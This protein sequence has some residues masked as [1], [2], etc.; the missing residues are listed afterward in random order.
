MINIQ[1]QR[2][3]INQGISNLINEIKDDNRSIL[4]IENNIE[5][6]VT[7]ELILL[8]NIKTLR[9]KEDSNITLDIKLKQM[10]QDLIYKEKKLI[11]NQGESHVEITNSSYKTIEILNN[12]DQILE[13]KA[14][15]LPIISLNKKNKFNIKIEITEKYNIYINDILTSE[16]YYLNENKLKIGNNEIIFDK[17]FKFVINYERIKSNNNV[18]MLNGISDI[19]LCNKEY[20]G[21]KLI[22]G[23][24]TSTSISLEK[25]NNINYIDIG[26][27][28]VEIKE[29][30]KELKC[31]NSLII[32]NNGKNN[33]IESINKIGSEQSI[34]LNE[35]V[36]L[37]SNIIEE[38]SKIII[39]PTN[40]KISNNN[41]LAKVINNKDI[42][43]TYNN[44][45]LL[46]QGVLNTNKIYTV[47]VK[48]YFINVNGVKM[49]DGDIVISESI[50]NDPIY[51][52]KFITNIKEEENIIFY[53][54][55]AKYYLQNCHMVNGLTVDL[56]IKNI[57][58]EYNND[59]YL[60]NG[61]KKMKILDGGIL[62][63]NFSS[64]TSDQTNNIINIDANAS[65]IMYQKKNSS[66]ILYT[67]L[68]NG[69][70]ELNNFYDIS[71]SAPLYLE[72]NSLI[73]GN[74][75]NTIGEDFSNSF[76]I[77]SG[78]KDIIA[79]LAKE[80]EQYP[81][82]TN[83]EKI[84]IT[85]RKNDDLL[86]NTGT[87]NIKLK[88]FYGKDLLYKGSI[89][90]NDNNI[91]IGD[92]IYTLN[93][94]C[95]Y[96]PTFIGEEEININ[97]NIKINTTNIKL[98]QKI[99][100]DL[101]LESINHKQFYMKNYYLKNYINFKLEYKD[102]YCNLFIKQIDESYIACA[103][104]CGIS[105]NNVYIDQGSLKGFSGNSS[106]YILY[107]IE[108]N[109]V[110]IRNENFKKGFSSKNENYLNIEKNKI[111]L[112]S[113]N[114]GIYEIIQDNT[115]FYLNNECPYFC[116]DICTL[117]TYENNN[118]NLYL[119]K[120]STT[121]NNI[122]FSSETFQLV[123][124]ANT[125]Y[126]NF[127]WENSLVNAEYGE[128]R[129]G[130]KQYP[131][132]YN[133]LLKSG[134]FIPPQTIY[135][136]L[137]LKIFSNNFVV[138]F[139]ENNTHEI[140]LLN[141]YNL[142]GYNSVFLN[143]NIYSYQDNKI[144]NLNINKE[145]DAS[146]LNINMNG[147][148]I[149]STNMFNDIYF[150]P[151]TINISKVTFN[152]DYPLF[153][154]L[155]KDK[156]NNL[157][158]SI[159]DMINHIY[160]NIF[161]PDVIRNIDFNLFRL[162]VDNK[163]IKKPSNSIINYCNSISSFSGSKNV[164]KKVLYNGSW[165]FYTLEPSTNNFYKMI[166]YDTNL[167]ILPVNFYI[168][169]YFN[170]TN[171]VIDNLEITQDVNKN[172][173]S[174]KI[175]NNVIATEIAG[176]QSN[177]N[178]FFIPKSNNEII[179]PTSINNNLM[180]CK[181]L[182]DTLMIYNN[183]DNKLYYTSSK[184]INNILYDFSSRLPSDFF[185]LYFG[186][187]GASIKINDSKT[188]SAPCNTLNLKSPDSLG[189]LGVNNVTI[190]VPSVFS[191]E[192]EIDAN[193]NLKLNITNSNVNITNGNISYTINDFL[194]NPNYDGLE[195]GDNIRLDKYLTKPLYA[196]DTGAPLSLNNAVINFSNNNILLPNGKYIVYNKPNLS[197][198]KLKNN[199]KDIEIYNDLFPNGF[200]IHNYNEVLGSTTLTIDGNG[201]SQNRGKTLSC[202][203]MNRG[204]Y[205]SNNKE[206]YDNAK[207]S[208]K[209]TTAN[210][211]GSFIARVGSETLYLPEQDIYLNSI[212]KKDCFYD[213]V[214]ASSNKLVALGKNNVLKISTGTT[215]YINPE[216]QD[217][218]APGIINLDNLLLA[219]TV[220][221]SQ[222]I[223]DNNGN[224]IDNLYDLKIFSD[225][226]FKPFIFYGAYNKSDYDNKLT[227]SLCNDKT[228]LVIKY[229]SSTKTK[230]ISNIYNQDNTLNIEESN[231]NI[232]SK[233][234]VPNSGN[235]LDSYVLNR[236]IN[237][238]FAWGGG[239][240][241]K[242]KLINNFQSYAP[243]ICSF[244][245]NYLYLYTI[246]T[247]G[248]CYKLPL[249]N[250]NSIFN[251]SNPVILKAV[252][253]GIE[254]NY[255]NQTL[256]LYSNLFA[257][258]LENNFY[259]PANMKYWTLP[260]EIHNF[261]NMKVFT[262]RSVVL[263]Y[264]KNSMEFSNKNA[265]MTDSPIIKFNLDTYNY[266]SP[267]YL[268]VNQEGIYGYELKNPIDTM[269][270]NKI[271]TGT[272]NKYNFV[273]F[274]NSIF[275]MPASTTTLNYLFGNSNI[276]I[277]NRYKTLEVRCV[278][279]NLILD[280]IDLNNNKF[281]YVLNKWLNNN[282]VYSGYTIYTDLNIILGNNSYNKNIIEFS[283]ITPI[284]TT[285]AM[286]LF[287]YNIKLN[288][289]CVYTIVENNKLN[290]SVRD[291][292][293]NEKYA[294]K[295]A[296]WLTDTT[297]KIGNT[298]YG[299][300]T[301][302]VSGLG[303]IAFNTANRSF[304]YNIDSGYNLNFF[305]RQNITINEK[306]N[307]KLIGDNLC[308]TNAN[309]T[310]VRWAL[311]QNFD[312]YKL[313]NS[314]IDY[315]IIAFTGITKV[316]LFSRKN[317]TVASPCVIYLDNTNLDVGTYLL[318]NWSSNPLYESFTLD[319]LNISYGEV[320]FKSPVNNITL[321]GRKGIN[322][323][324]PCT[325][326][327]EN[328]N[329][330]F[331]GQ[332]FYIENWTENNNLDNCDIGDKY[333]GSNLKGKAVFT[334]SVSNMF[335]FGRNFI[336]IIEPVSLCLS[337]NHLKVF[338]NAN[339]LMYDWIN[340]TN[341]DGV[342]L[343]NNYISHG[344]VLFLRETQNMKLFERNMNVINTRQN[345]D[346][347]IKDNT[348]KDK[349]LTGLYTKNSAHIPNGIALYKLL[350][351]SN[352]LY[353]V[354]FT[355][356][357]IIHDWKINKKCDNI[358]L[359]TSYISGNEEVSVSVTSN[360][361]LL[362]F[363]NTAS[364]TTNYYY[365]LKNNDL[366]C[367]HKN[368]IQLNG[369]W[370]PIS[371][372]ALFNW[373]NKNDL[374]NFTIGDVNLNDPRVVFNGAK[375][376]Q[377]YS[378]TKID[379]EGV[380]SAKLIDGIHLN[381][382]EN[383]FVIYNWLGAS[384]DASYTSRTTNVLLSAN[385]IPSGVIKFNKAINTINLFGR[386]NVNIA[387]KNIAFIKD[388]HLYMCD[389]ST[390]TG[391]GA[392]SL[393]ATSINAL[394]PYYY[395][396]WLTD[397][398]YNKA[399]VGLCTLSQ[400]TLYVKPGNVINNFNLFTKI[401]GINTKNNGNV[402]CSFLADNNNLVVNGDN[403]A[404][405]TLV[406]WK[407]TDVYKT[408]LIGTWIFNDANFIIK[409]A[410]NIQFFNRTGIQISDEYQAKLVG[411][412]LYNA[413]ELYYLTD[414][415]T[416]VNYNNSI[417]NN[418]I[419]DN[420]TSKFVALKPINNL[421]LWGVKTNINNSYYNETSNLINVETTIRRNAGTVSVSYKLPDYTS[422]SKYIIYGW[423]ATDTI[424]NPLNTLANYN[425]NT[426]Y[427]KDLLLSSSMY[428]IAGAWNVT[429]HNRKYINIDN[430][431]INGIANPT[432][433]TNIDVYAFSGGVI[434]TNDISIMDGDRNT[435]HLLIMHSGEKTL[436]NNDDM[437]WIIINN[438]SNDI[439]YN[440]NPLNSIGILSTY[441]IFGLSRDI[442]ATTNL[443]PSAVD[444]KNYKL[445]SF[446]QAN[447]ISLCNQNGIKIRRNINESI[448]SFTPYVSKYGAATGNNLYCVENSDYYLY[449]FGLSTAT[450]NARSIIG[451]AY[452]Q[453]GPTSTMNIVTANKKINFCLNG[454][455]SW[456]EAYSFGLDTNKN[457]YL[458]D[459]L[460]NTNLNNSKIVYNNI[461]SN[462][463]TNAYFGVRAHSNENY[464]SSFKLTFANI[465]FL[466]N[467]RPINASANVTFIL[468]MDDLTV[469]YVDAIPANSF[470]Y[471]LVN[472]NKE[473]ALYGSFVLGSS[474][475]S[476]AN[477][478]DKMIVKDCNNIT[479]F[480]RKI[481]TIKG[482]Y[483][484]TLIN[485]DLVSLFGAS[486]TLYN[487][488]TN[489]TTYPP[490]MILESSVIPANLSVIKIPKGGNNFNIFGLKLNIDTSYT[491]ENGNKIDIPII[492]IRNYA[493]GSSTVIKSVT[494]TYRLPT[495]SVDTSYDIYGWAN[496]TPSGLN[497]LNY[498]AKTI[499]VSDFLETCKQGFLIAKASNVNLHNRVGINIDNTLF[500]NGLNINTYAGG[501]SITN[502]LTEY[503]SDTSGNHLL[504]K[505]DMEAGLTKDNKREKE[506][507]IIIYNWKTDTRYDGNPT[508]TIG[509]L[510]YFNNN[511]AT[512]L[513]NYNYT[514]T[515]NGVN[516]NAGDTS[517]ASFGAYFINAGDI[518]YST[519]ENNA[520]NFSKY[521]L[522]SFLRANNIRL[523][524]KDGAGTLLAK[525]NISIRRGADVVSFTPFVGL[526]QNYNTLYSG[527][528]AIC[529]LSLFFA[530][531][532]NYAY[533]WDSVL[534]RSLTGPGFLGNHYFNS[535]NYDF[536]L[537]T[538]K[539]SQY[540]SVVGGNI[541]LLAIYIRG[542]YDNGKDCSIMIND[543]KTTFK[544]DSFAFL[545][546]N[547][548]DYNN[549]TLNYYISDS[550]VA[551][552]FSAS[553][554]YKQVFDFNST[555]Y[556]NVN[557]SYY[558]FNHD[559]RLNYNNIRLYYN[560][561]L[562]GV[563]GKK[564]SFVGIACDVDN[565]LGSSTVLQTI[566]YVN[567]NYSNKKLQVEGK[568]ATTSY[569]Y[570][571]INWGEADTN[572]AGK[573]K[574]YSEMALGTQSF[575]ME[576]ANIENYIIA[577]AKNI[578]YFGVTNIN[579]TGEYMAKLVNYN[580]YNLKYKY[581][582]LNW[583]N[584]AKFSNIGYTLN[585]K[586]INNEP[587]NN[588]MIKFTAS[589]DNIVLPG[590]YPNS[591]NLIYRQNKTSP[592]NTNIVIEKEIPLTITWYTDYETAICRVSDGVGYY[593]IYGWINED[594]ILGAGNLNYSNKTIYDTSIKTFNEGYY[595]VSTNNLTIGNRIGININNY[596]N[597]TMVTGGAR[598]TNIL[599]GYDNDASGDHLMFKHELDLALNSPEKIKNA[600]H[601]YIIYN[602]N[603]DTRYNNNIL[604]TIGL[605]SNYNADTSG[606]P[607][608]E[609]LSLTG[610]G[611]AYSSHNVNGKFVMSEL[612][613]S[614]AN[615]SKYRL[616]SFLQ[617]NNIKLCHV[618]NVKITRNQNKPIKSFTPYR[619]YLTNSLFYKSF[620]EGGALYFV[621]SINYVYRNWWPS[622]WSPCTEANY[623]N[624]TIGN[625]YVERLIAPAYCV[626]TSNNTYDGGASSFNIEINGVNT[627]ISEAAFFSTGPNFSD[628]WPLDITT[629]K[630]TSI[631][632]NAYKIYYRIFGY[633]SNNYSNTVINIY[634]FKNA[635]KNGTN[636][637][638]AWDPS[639]APDYVMR[640]YTFNGVIVG[641][642]GLNSLNTVAN[643]RVWNYI[644]LSF[645]NSELTMEY[646]ASQSI[647]NET[648]NVPYA[649]KYT[650]VNWGVPDASKN[651]RDSIYYELALG[652]NTFN[653]TVITNM[654]NYILKDCINLN[655]HNRT[656]I[657]IKGS[658]Q[659][660]INNNNLNIVG[661]DEY[662]YY[663][664]INDANW[665]R[666]T[667]GD[668]I[669]YYPTGYKGD[670]GVISIIK[671]KTFSN[672]HE[673][674][675]VTISN[676]NNYFLKYNYLYNRSGLII[677]EQRF[678]IMDW[679]EASSRYDDAIL[680]DF[681]D[682]NHKT[683]LIR[684]LNDYTFNS[685]LGVPN[686]SFKGG[687][688][689]DTILDSKSNVT[690]LVI[691]IPSSPRS[692]N[693]F[694]IYS[695]S[696]WS[697]ANYLNPT[698]G[699]NV[700]INSS[701]N[702]HAKITF[703][704]DGGIY[705]YYGNTNVRYK[706]IANLC[707]DA[708]YDS[709]G[710]TINNV[711][712]LWITKGTTAYFYASDPDLFCLGNYY[713]YN[714]SALRVATYNSSKDLPLNQPFY[715]GRKIGYNSLKYASNYNFSKED[716]EV[717]NIS[718]GHGTYYI[719]T[720]ID[721]P[722]DIGENWIMYY[723]LSQQRSGSRDAYYNLNEVTF[724]CNNRKIYRKLGDFN[725][726][727]L[728]NTY[729]A[730]EN[731]Y[732]TPSKSRFIMI[733][734]PDH[735]F[736]NKEGVCTHF[737][738]F[739]LDISFLAPNPSL[740]SWDQ[741]Q[742]NRAIGI[743]GLYTNTVR[744]ANVIWANRSGIEFAPSITWN[745][746][747]GS[748]T[749]TVNKYLDSYCLVSGSFDRQSPLIF[750]HNSPYFS[751]K[752]IIVYSVC[753]GSGTTMYIKEIAVTIRPDYKRLD[754][755]VCHI[756]G[757]RYT[758][759]NINNIG[760]YLKYSIYNDILIYL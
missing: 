353:A 387:T 423:Y 28:I 86:I 608:A 316:D 39:N 416:D 226:T 27:Y 51:E 681:L 218:A 487:W 196:H 43:I 548:T 311:D 500:N 163:I 377:L 248:I 638:I 587:T 535:L 5:E 180:K 429:L 428:Y 530:E 626:I 92:E 661:C 736:N 4:R 352:D 698:L 695:L 399:S 2:I 280:I 692:L 677:T 40:V 271:V 172:A 333:I 219:Y 738:D 686:V 647:D 666:S 214:C 11:I 283:N 400:G 343:C 729:Y 523:A 667:I 346:L 671:P 634:E 491:D 755:E 137:N 486:Y 49:E 115:I 612:V 268:Y 324:T 123:N 717:M 419:I 447:N 604:G 77:T 617:A 485:N 451:N 167:N 369:V 727:F 690:G 179:L 365:K 174:I 575:G 88:Y 414:W 728:G 465:N 70:I 41:I 79:S 577:D 379:I 757:A 362:L 498:E 133:G 386:E 66:L 641:L 178:V 185:Y 503:D 104:L 279:E 345:I 78:E 134:V 15:D 532:K 198:Y 289:T 228:H 155:E 457:L 433:N 574:I 146:Y 480:N 590:V 59:F 143:D 270:I 418:F 30:T 140:K 554:L 147:Y 171:R 569:S 723:N 708:N 760:D 421:L 598:I 210:Y 592:V 260:R 319:S 14:G 593:N 547:K 224:I 125:I 490:T 517:Y 580:L 445:I 623:Y 659:S 753:P 61:L 302:P 594:Y 507:W 637:Y 689:V 176:N 450:N 250:M 425:N 682:Y 277:G 607:A 308:I 165:V 239:N 184:K 542:T 559:N 313:Y 106:D 154:G 706:D 545:S 735:V 406:K 299:T 669:I 188:F 392:V 131:F 448:K 22:N 170:N 573:D 739:Q 26:G 539:N 375:N 673:R 38:N 7:G 71:Y 213:A 374:S 46:F 215:Y 376:I 531:S 97:S 80:N 103:P 630:T 368:N 412:H 303:D 212:N 162:T 96:S 528:T 501:V 562:G 261:N 591:N 309:Y 336:N 262:D 568:T 112:T 286:F 256:N 13:F 326:K 745:L 371:S 275:T 117:L 52:E 101:I 584:K 177:Y 473:I 390:I 339:Y 505:Y 32:E 229:D 161:T 494:V 468:Y 403:L 23:I 460:L 360:G 724:L 287:N 467:D 516:P 752:E 622:I 58:L 611:T 242:T 255:R 73:Y 678:V 144:I 550:R 159:N 194:N 620:N 716:P 411:N 238:C 644:K 466:Y 572:N 426:I 307:A 53:K 407:N 105:E 384:M 600:M 401:T 128:L 337:D 499:K 306:I 383:D 639:A 192:A 25:S 464:N 511:P 135:K 615:F 273:P 746:A 402:G 55:K 290:V 217:N 688:G 614:Q 643:Y 721:T 558:E 579:I 751:K 356:N 742:N 193:N 493:N 478:A 31:I 687:A 47:D 405:Y 566:N 599:T 410:K 471:T 555:N 129:I 696:N 609:S 518:T 281:N 258:W 488:A 272:I 168:Y 446:V 121:N 257:Y 683:F 710:F 50:N 452:I 328:K 10:I 204:Y 482:P 649:H 627:N 397:I 35:K 672:F 576:K 285:A 142:K 364:L 408:F 100:D 85:S 191:S 222:S 315:G 189:L 462:S 709:G 354:D 75:K 625:H 398:T 624:H 220:E 432:A 322:I 519:L 534:L 72:N 563:T 340:D 713:L 470:N 175:D 506:R 616:I 561:G 461:N 357:Y 650:L 749:I 750:T 67:N 139:L 438:W 246:N 359:G 164:I 529:R 700:Y 203:L 497:S 330:M 351:R 323:K 489:A 618:S 571:I 578:T 19:F 76:Y 294:Y 234:A 675:N 329:L 581:Y 381:N 444:F 367:S 110:N 714:W 62:T 252:N 20:F 605:M 642:S 201:I 565:I 756:N 544:E 640:Q 69:V 436:A 546:M 703:I 114:G 3:L 610:Q 200:Y 479:Y 475:F 645:D 538:L 691:S 740:Y 8:D 199:N 91:V 601:W 524:I 635:N 102:K 474:I 496:N 648:T 570:S 12:N 685:F 633:N 417:L 108:K 126:K 527:T 697:P 56:S 304:I 288:G 202:Q 636:I 64:I 694:P 113:K 443:I 747:G 34:I 396:N 454:V 707:F 207:V 237:R 42:I 748:T 652:N 668:G 29:T 393:N 265:N 318:E 741:G 230:Y 567:L 295:I 93:G 149:N 205:L 646:R 298:Q 679:L 95:V 663:N 90:L 442:C 731:K 231:M 89:T 267:L 235:M 6:K 553:N 632:H 60:V 737:A 158:I 338:D 320:V 589:C 208:C 660:V 124:V 520:A 726:T 297:N 522:I 342:S 720:L 132:I 422:E 704:N 341:F 327:I 651:L 266:N 502:D 138:S 145:K 274:E 156:N 413:N 718:W 458:G 169:D 585:N 483:R 236:D 240:Y 253:G 588:L 541:A 533:R 181:S 9:I 463:Y 453:N 152:T 596:F 361:S 699:H 317:I 166:L 225:T 65:I 395:K 431:L 350:N 420:S 391:F 16:I 653:N 404:Y 394:I 676:I 83:K 221:S 552:S 245:T 477:G 484:A 495:A 759:C 347:T 456:I 310:I 551:G 334:T 301:S 300:A 160:F 680:D 211:F 715:T 674:S 449:N 455:N 119:H 526:M 116:N 515:I 98:M 206:L 476:M 658:A 415:N 606:A 693:T 130:S 314:R 712:N 619:G 21:L 358:T 730:I 543:V 603:K 109:Q 654:N 722:I 613:N 583:N 664:W 631:L 549:Y 441:N 684:F 332:S 233:G 670:S 33:V 37:G 296:D 560:P 312:N 744:R 151:K 380:F 492:F 148:A 370:Q 373:Y 409:N 725:L 719:K 127:I 291:A 45:T 187:N 197:I 249:L 227:K 734:I 284:T 557:I 349:T 628:Y 758:F 292:N 508:G 656:N 459:V 183:N 348:G 251:A 469:S 99:G 186:E 754:L 711:K 74:I 216:I 36:Q 556:A 665:N 136:K 120:K 540:S 657:N 94:E 537:T 733:T 254:I 437:K 514:A 44:Q 141:E 157:F 335:L 382:I 24:N 1:I 107:N 513:K 595:I 389:E 424:L 481:Q 18:L 122:L 84:L 247:T 388:T 510:N 597:S 17:D 525:D 629:L 586:V 223:A 111:Y 536:N 521:R 430:T 118:I 173:F 363:D 621:E 355:G 655:Y 244:D 263:N 57:N 582:I 743:V 602:W 264:N 48:D 269:D 243:V 150:C 344:S 63:S 512:G 378:K 153:L 190:N 87:L 439:R 564:Y 68:S 331:K 504:I 321:F 705:D 278:K 440:N 325:L 702:D 293:W 434:I 732:I 82:I 472:W 662:V 182:Q 372:Y 427:I 81:H 305:G 54:R 366:V 232:L 435:D 241:L 276:K 385:R 209:D 509:I 195:L 259:A 701:Y 282:T